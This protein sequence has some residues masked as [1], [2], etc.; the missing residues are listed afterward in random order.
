VLRLHASR[1]L[2]LPSA[3][4][5]CFATSAAAESVADFYRGKQLRMV[6]ANPPGG[7]Y[8]S[9]GRLM[10][11]HIDRHIPGNPQIVVQNMPGAGSRLAT[12]WL[13]NVAPRDGSVI[14]LLGQGTPTDEALKEPGVQFETAKFN[15]IGNPSIDNNV[16]SVLATSGIKTLEDVKTKGSLICAG[17]GASSPSVMYPQVLNN[18][19]GSSIR[20]IFG[21][22]GS[23]EMDIA[24]ERGEVN[25]RAGSTWTGWRAEKADWLR[26]P[27]NQFLRAMGTEKEPRHL[28]LYGS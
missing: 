11:A 5:L 24:M 26:E 7:G 27:Q 12:N 2:L 17:S 15:W 18:L 14:G 4:V 13:Y 22:P 16:S 20:I 8:D 10:A 23:P 19:T 1:A 21:Y 9:Y 3:F 25:C 28:A 6:I